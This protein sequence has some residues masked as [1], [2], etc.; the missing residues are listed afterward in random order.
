MTAGPPEAFDALANLIALV[1][2]AK[3]CAKRLSELRAQIELATGAQV[4]L[5]ADRLEHAQKVAADTAELAGREA[6]L[7]KRHVAVSIRER[8]A[9]EREQRFA[10]ALPPRYPHDPNLFGTLTREP[11]H[12]G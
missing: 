4:K 2:D 8:E 12:H 11:E 5:D 3:A 7:R 10:D 9:G 1:T 6:V